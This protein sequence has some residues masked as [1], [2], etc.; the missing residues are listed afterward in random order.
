MEFNYRFYFDQAL[1][2]I[3]EV[4]DP[5]SQRPETA[6]LKWDMVKKQVIFNFGGSEYE[7]Y[8]RVHDFAQK[9]S[10][11]ILAFIIQRLSEQYG[12]PLLPVEDHYNDEKISVPLFTFLDESCNTMLF[13]KEIEECSIWKSK[14]IEPKPVAQIIKKYGASD[15]KYIYLMYDYA[16]L[17]VVGHNDDVSDPGRGYNLYSL[18]WFFETYFGADEYGRFLLYL[19]EYI[20]KVESYLGYILVRTLTPNTLINFRKITEHAIIVYP[21]TELLNINSQKYYLNKNEFEKIRH[22]FFDENS[23]TV[24]LG[25]HD[26]AESLITAEWMYKSVKKACAID[27]T[28][29]GMGYFKAVEQLLYELICLWKDTGLFVKK[30]YSYENRELPEF[31]P[32]SSENIEAGLIDF[33]IGA[34]AN[35]V[36]NC[37]KNNVPIFREE[38]LAPTKKYIREYLFNFA[39]LRNGYFHKHNIHDWGVIDEIRSSAFRTMFLLLGAFN[40]SKESLITLGAPSFEAFTDYARLCEYV[41]YHSNEPFYLISGKKELLLSSCTD[42]QPQIINNEYIRYSGAYFKPLGKS[43][44]VFRLDEEHLPKEI[45]LGKLVFSQSEKPEFS[46]IKVKKV[47][48]NG[49]YIGPSIAEEDSFDY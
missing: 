22:Q 31:I 2:K 46:M 47:F 3:R 11:S 6:D 25:S 49:R 4:R 17:Q 41:N 14:K 20:W 19:K 27:L 34:M 28:T 18:K 26:F 7:K 8:S 39:D 33:S 5:H 32:L 12:K 38:L 37:V 1:R 15:C 13:F 42:Q 16:Y 24:L 23:F 45:Y 29:V 10:V 40:L 30:D 9:A 21:Y 43:G 48:E 36:K 35:I 44:E